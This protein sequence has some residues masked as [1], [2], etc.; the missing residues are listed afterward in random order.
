[1]ASYAD[2]TVAIVCAL[3]IEMIAVR[4]MFDQEHPRLPRKEGDPNIYYVGRLCG[5]NVVLAGLP[6][7][8]GKGAAAIVATNL[9]RT[10]PSIQ[11]RLLVGIGG[12]VPSVKH[13]IR[14]GDVVVS[15]PE[16]THGGVVQYDLGKAQQVS[17][18][19]SIIRAYSPYRVLSTLVDSSSQANTHVSNEITCFPFAG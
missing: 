18:Q 16:G 7:T 15:M 17:T 8:Q 2:Y 10:F 14:L 12:G 19:D 4:S 9:N 6:G 3:T 1:M 11:W 13:D 5:H